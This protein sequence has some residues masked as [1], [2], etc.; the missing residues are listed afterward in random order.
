MNATM[1]LL[2]HAMQRSGAI[3][4]CSSACV[5]TCNWNQTL[6]CIWRILRL[7]PNARGNPLLMMSLSYY[8]NFCRDPCCYFDRAPNNPISRPSGWIGTNPSTLAPP[9]IGIM[10]AHRFKSGFFSFCSI[11]PISCLTVSCSQSAGGHTPPRWGDY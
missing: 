3:Y 5:F 9:S 2:R 1:R 8:P 4:A 11:I 6:L 10:D 7:L